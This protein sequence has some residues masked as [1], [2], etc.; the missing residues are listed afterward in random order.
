MTDA[1]RLRAANPHYPGWLLNLK[2]GVFS[3]DQFEV[4]MA[5]EDLLVS[6]MRALDR[7]ELVWH[8]EHADKPEG[9]WMDRGPGYFWE[10]WRWWQWLLVGWWLLWGYLVVSTALGGMPGWILGQVVTVAWAL[11]TALLAFLF[12]TN[13]E[14][15]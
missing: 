7:R 6:V 9:W 5:A 14:T 3:S 15:R 2:A 13:A 1:E 10:G 11:F 8:P 12:L 4:S